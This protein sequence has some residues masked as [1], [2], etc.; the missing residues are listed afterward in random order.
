[1]GWGMGWQPEYDRWRGYN[2]PALCDHPECTTEIDRGLFFICEGCQL[3]FC[4]LHLQYVALP[5]PEKL[6][7]QRCER[8]AEG[9]PQ[10]QPGPELNTWLRHVLTH[11][12]WEQW[13]V[14]NPGLAKRY[15][16]DYDRNP[17]PD[18]RKAEQP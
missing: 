14:E 9:K 10:W 1:M 17:V 11:D 16:Q 3:F 7:E 2:V 12:S 13:R 8:C 5:G 15:Q 4:A 6:T 18:D